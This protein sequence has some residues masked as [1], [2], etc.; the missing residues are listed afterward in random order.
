MAVKKHTLAL[1][2]AATVF[3]GSTVVAPKPADAGFGDWLKAVG[4]WTTGK[5][6]KYTAV[7]K[8]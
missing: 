4:C 1:A 2:I 7:C 6:S 5:F 8:K 3:A